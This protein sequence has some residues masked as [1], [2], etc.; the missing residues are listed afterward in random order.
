[1][2]YSLIVLPAVEQQLAEALRERP[3]AAIKRALLAEI[4]A[5]FDQI[6]EMPRRFPVAYGAVHR[7]L[8]ARFH[9][10]VFFEIEE[11]RAEVVVVGGVAS[12]PRS[13]AVAETLG[14]AGRHGRARGC[15]A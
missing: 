6:V 4:A 1:M 11:P 2:S 14:A 8:T 15:F 12:A 5:T 13:G 7:A 9:F 3:D 10:A